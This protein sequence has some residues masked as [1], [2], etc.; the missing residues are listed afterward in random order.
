[1]L[2]TGNSYVLFMYYTAALQTQRNIRRLCFG[3]I[4]SLSRF[5]DSER[6]EEATTRER[7]VC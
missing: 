7:T 6:N 3:A 4:G 5:C 1:M 2:I